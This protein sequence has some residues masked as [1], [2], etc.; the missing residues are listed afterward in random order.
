MYAKYSIKEANIVKMIV[1]LELIPFCEI[2][3]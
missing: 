2:I 3:F 1:S